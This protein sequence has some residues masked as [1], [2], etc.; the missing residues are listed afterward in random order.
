M[1]VFVCV[2]TARAVD[3]SRPHH[4]AVSSDSALLYEANYN[5]HVFGKQ[6]EN[7]FVMLVMTLLPYKT[8]V[9][10]LY[11]GFSVVFH[12]LTAVTTP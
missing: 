9:D 2:R 12:K 11:H 3:G 8:T 5:L 6:F 7:L 4:D 10:S 1:S